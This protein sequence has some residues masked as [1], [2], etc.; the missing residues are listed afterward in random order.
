M[1]YLYLKVQV[2]QYPE[3]NTTPLIII[4]LVWIINTIYKLIWPLKDILKDQMIID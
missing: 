3:N 1:I 2:V 4:I